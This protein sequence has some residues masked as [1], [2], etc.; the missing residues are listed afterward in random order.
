MIEIGFWECIVI[1]LIAFIVLGP[2]R[3]PVV[4]RVLGRWFA[5][6]KRIVQSL[7]QDIV[8]EIHQERDTK[9]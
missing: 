7:K 9:K 6:A 5:R 1:L 8:E 3:M 2:E 4:A